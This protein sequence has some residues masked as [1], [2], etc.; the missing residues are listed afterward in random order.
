MQPRD[1]PR[2]GRI[3]ELESLVGVTLG[4]TAWR[5]VRQVDVDQFAE[6]TGDQQWIHVD[7]VRASAGTFGG[8]VAHGLL[9]LSL[10]PALM[11]ELI[12]LSAFPQSLNYGYDMIRF[13]APVPVGERVR[14]TGTIVAVDRRASGTVLIRLTQRIEVEGSIRPAC[15]ADSLV[16]VGPA[17]ARA[18]TTA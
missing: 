13:P 5:A 10:G 1:R 7:I 3:D 2:P 12:D 18:G 14:A 8:T 15:V 17:S 6:L 9:T 16:L 4:P 11:Q